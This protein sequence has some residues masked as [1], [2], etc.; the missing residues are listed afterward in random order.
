MSHAGFPVLGRRASHAVTAPTV[1]SLSRP[2]TATRWGT[3]N[4]RRPLAPSCQAAPRRWCRPPPPYRWCWRSWW[5]WWRP[6]WWLWREWCRGGTLDWWVVL[7]SAVISSAA[8]VIHEIAGSYGAESWR[9]DDCSQCSEG[10]GELF[11]LSWTCL[12]TPWGECKWTGWLVSGRT[13]GMHR[14]NSGLRV[15]W[16]SASSVKPPTGWLLPPVFLVCDQGLASPQQSSKALQSAIDQ[17]TRR[18]SGS[19]FYQCEDGRPGDSTVGIEGRCLTCYG[20]SGT[21]K[22]N[23]DTRHTSPPT[24]A[25]FFIVIDTILQSV[26]FLTRVPFLVWRKR[27]FPEEYRHTMHVRICNECV[28]LLR[29]I[30]TVMVLCGSLLDVCDPCHSRESVVCLWSMSFQGECGM[31]VIHVIPGRVWYVCDPC[32]S[33]ESVVCLWS[34][35]FEGECDM[36]VIHVIPGRVWYVCDPC[37]SRESVI[38]LWSI[39]VIPGRVW[40]VCDPCHSRESV[41]CL[42]SMG[43]CGMFDLIPTCGCE[44]DIL[45]FTQKWD[46]QKSAIQFLNRESVRRSLIPQHNCLGC[47]LKHEPNTCIF[48]PFSVAFFQ[49]GSSRA[50]W[51]QTENLE[52]LDH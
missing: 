17:W 12:F 6:G 21:R 43:G 52:A 9:H 44:R 49:Q 2:T 22:T 14:P 36:F 50:I 45:G 46:A 3:S 29:W 16:R 40:Y 8:G 30:V 32:H 25:H 13:F 20:A 15:E 19:F 1:T 51:T 26:V 28:S 38:C 24:Y 5:L 41:V 4:P 7:I 39:K 33:R 23:T 48:C 10:S 11:T 37:H 35:S 31:F 34:M 47:S 27:I 42:W 18:S